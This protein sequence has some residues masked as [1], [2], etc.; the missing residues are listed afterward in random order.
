MTVDAF[1]SYPLETLNIRLIISEDP[2]AKYYIL[3]KIL[4]YRLDIGGL[5]VKE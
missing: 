3:G 1:I 5:Y 4:N 2:E